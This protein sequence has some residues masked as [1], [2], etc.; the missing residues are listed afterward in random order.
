MPTAT[1]APISPAA[2]RLA[3]HE[4]KRRNLTDRQVAKFWSDRNVEYRDI[5][6]RLEVIDR[7]IEEAWDLVHRLKS[8]GVR[9]AGTPKQAT[10][11]IAGSA[12]AAWRC[13]DRRDTPHDDDQ[14]TAVAAAMVA[15]IE[16]AL[17]SKEGIAAMWAAEFARVTAAS[18]DP[19]DRVPPMKLLAR[20]WPERFAGGQ[21]RGLR[22]PRYTDWRDVEPA[23]W[24]W[25]FWA[26]VPNPLTTTPA[27]L[28]R[29][30]AAVDA[31][32][33]RA[34]AAQRKPRETAAG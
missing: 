25:S 28:R 13:H 4:L 8:A 34:M 30:M 5:P 6:R 19:L 11:T 26:A 31:T 7:L 15:G 33:R 1:L 27:A 18:A 29:A 16:M 21:L 3:A 32:H 2:R 22:T 17:A 10:L 12:Y 20:V 24:D 23:D 9:W 14:G